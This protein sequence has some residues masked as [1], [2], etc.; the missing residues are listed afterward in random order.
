M[1][2]A[3]NEQSYLFYRNFYKISDNALRAANN[4]FA[5]RLWPMDHDFETRYR[6]TQPTIPSRTVTLAS[7]EKD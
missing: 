2:N 4:T 3:V 7:L 1:T 6:S 5:G